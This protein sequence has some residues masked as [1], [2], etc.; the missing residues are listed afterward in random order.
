MRNR[1]EEEITVFLK[2]K[3]YEHAFRKIVSCYKEPLYFKIRNMLVVHADTDDALQNTFIKIWKYLPQFKMES[4]VFSWC[5]R[6]AINEAIHQSKQVAK[7][8]HQEISE[9]VE[10]AESAHAQVYTN[11][12]EIEAMLNEAVLTL[13]A[14]QKRVF[15]AKYFEGKK[16]SE[17]LDEFGGSIGGLKANYHHA[18]QKI[19]N[20]IKTKVQH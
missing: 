10:F 7:H 13:P 4:Q 15:E 19:E 6:I 12:Q 5:F 17:I 2:Q 14:K 11:G 18:V 3:D 20:F 1:V 16:Y 9:L 8:R